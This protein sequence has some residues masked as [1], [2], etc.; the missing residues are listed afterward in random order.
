MFYW[1]GPSVYAYIL[2]VKLGDFVIIGTAF[3]VDLRSCCYIDCCMSS[4][5]GIYWSEVGIIDLADADDNLQ[6]ITSLEHVV[7]SNTQG[8]GTSASDV[9]SHIP[10]VQM[11]CKLINEQNAQLQDWKAF[12]WSLS[13]KLSHLAKIIVEGWPRTLP[14]EGHSLISPSG[15]KL[16]SV[17]DIVHH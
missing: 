16:N 2:C 1:F 15:R 17:K 8:Q 12:P 13:G 10:V 7:S 5:T 4:L 6:Q 3:T 11:P 9:N 14:T